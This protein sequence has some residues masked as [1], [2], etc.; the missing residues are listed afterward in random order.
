[1]SIVPVGQFEYDLEKLIKT[2][3]SGGELPMT[4]LMALER[5]TKDMRAC[6]TYQD[7]LIAGSK[8]E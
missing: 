4:L 6:A 7:A 2:A 3:L 8:T 5:A 1:M